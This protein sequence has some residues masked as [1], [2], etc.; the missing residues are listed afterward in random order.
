MIISLLL[1]SV[2]SCAQRGRFSGSGTIKVLNSGG[3]RN[4]LQWRKSIPK[5]EVGALLEVKRGRLVQRGDGPQVRV[6]GLW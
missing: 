5:A 4:G 2:L 6:C 3:V 1:S